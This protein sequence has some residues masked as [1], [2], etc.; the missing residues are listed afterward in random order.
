M[1]PDI[2]TLQA[3]YKS[4]AGCKTEARLCAILNPMLIQHTQA[5]LLGLGYGVPFL[6]GVQTRVERLVLAMPAS[7]GVARWPLGSDNLACLVDDGSLPFTDSLFDQ[8]LVVHALEFAGPARRLLRELWR[9]L[10]PGGK[11]LFIVPNRT[12][13]HMLSPHSPFASGQPYTRQQ[14]H[15]LLT[16]ALFQPLSWQTALTLPSMLG[17]SRLD[18]VISQSGLGGVHIVE[19]TKQVGAM[20]K[21][22]PSAGKRVLASAPAH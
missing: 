11:L 22:Y 5:R 3:Y 1:R 17:G 9:V 10:A 21:T 18:H 19:A 16:E 7:Q 13:L 6:Q 15:S 12:S 20:P 14:L 2:Q 4:P 8:I